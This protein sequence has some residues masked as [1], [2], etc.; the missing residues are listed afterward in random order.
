MAS[1]AVDTGR[2]YINVQALGE[3]FTSETAMGIAAS[4]AVAKLITNSGYYKTSGSK[5]NIN[6]NVSDFMS[7][8]IK[9]IN[10]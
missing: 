3:K 5:Q 2:I 9:N 6:I 4:F 8:L 7:G 10:W 1:N